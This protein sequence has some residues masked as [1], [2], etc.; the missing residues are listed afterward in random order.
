M[1][2]SM[3]GVYKESDLEYFNSMLV[4]LQNKKDM[5]NDEEFLDIVKELSD[6]YKSLTK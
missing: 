6:T 1:V 4:Y 5:M 2:G 3:D